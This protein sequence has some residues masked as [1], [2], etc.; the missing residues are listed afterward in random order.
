ME[1]PKKIV[2]IITP[3]YR[4]FKEYEAEN[5]KPNEDYVFISRIKD[6]RGRYFNEL[7]YS[8]RSYLVDTDVV[9]AAL[10]RI[11]NI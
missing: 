6:V 1:T 8:V 5:K 11:R 10:R 7:K 2:G 3:Y 4:D 9:E